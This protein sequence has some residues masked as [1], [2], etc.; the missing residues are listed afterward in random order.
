[1]FVQLRSSS[2][3]LPPS[4]SIYNNNFIPVV[5]KTAYELLKD[6]RFKG[7]QVAIM[8][9]YTAQVAA[10]S[11]ATSRF[12]NFLLTH[13]KDTE[14]YLVGLQLKDVN[15]FTV[16]KMQGAQKDAILYCSTTSDKLR[17]TAYV[18]C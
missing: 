1:M 14:E 8:S 16:N 3:I 17:F 5:L 9:P 13:N 10:Y 7:S 2:S 4:K 6:S 11:H 12:V 15:V 18:T